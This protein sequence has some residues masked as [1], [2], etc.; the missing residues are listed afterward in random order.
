MINRI[1]PIS[2]P[3]RFN[4]MNILKLQKNYSQRIQAQ[5]QADFHSNELSSSN[6]TNRHIGY[7][8]EQQNYDV[9]QSTALSHVSSSLSHVSSSVSH[10]STMHGTS[11]VQYECEYTEIHQNSFHKFA[12][13]F[14]FL[15]FLPFPEFKNI[16]QRI[17]LKILDYEM[18]KSFLVQAA[19]LLLAKQIEYGK[20]VCERQHVG[21]VTESSIETMT[22]TIETRGKELQTKKIMD[23]MRFIKTMKHSRS[24][25]NQ[26]SKSHQLINYTSENTP[27]TL[28]QDSFQLHHF[29]NRIFLIIRVLYSMGFDIHESMFLVLLKSTMIHP[30]HF[31]L[32]G[33]N[34]H[35]STM[36]PRQ[37]LSESDRLDFVK[38]IET[39]YFFSR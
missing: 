33:I 34:Q 10:V 17:L 25:V 21:G 32:V 27:D 22:K 39:R 8:N 29:S 3:I 4:L 7:Q 18:K 19:H 15:T 23:F 37:I 16:L 38:W 24:K 31:L 14:A 26:Q 9:R 35:E 1:K 20:V 2:G 28:I 13:E 11:S 36:I 12:Q 5:E 6:D 30:D